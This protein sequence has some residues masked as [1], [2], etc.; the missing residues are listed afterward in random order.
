MN[1][2]GV[3]FKEQTEFNI[4]AAPSSVEASLTF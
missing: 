3:K 1:I 4:N 2:K